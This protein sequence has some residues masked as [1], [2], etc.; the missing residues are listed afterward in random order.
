MKKVETAKEKVSPVHRAALVRG[1]LGPNF[2]G[3]SG[4]V[5]A[6]LGVVLW[7]HRGEHCLPL[8]LWATPSHS[9]LWVS[10]FPQVSPWQ[11]QRKIRGK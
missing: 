8:V 6:D 3:L 4:A 2:A 7:K 11:K 1:Q 9:Q 10:S 5:S